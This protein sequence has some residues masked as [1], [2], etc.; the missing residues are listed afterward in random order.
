[1]RFIVDSSYSLMAP[2]LPQILKD[3]GVDESIN[4]YIFSTFSAALII[5]APLVG[6]YLSRYERMIFLR[7]GLFALGC[8]IL[9]FGLS[10]MIDNH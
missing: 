8:S 9:G 7:C 4:G 1:M 5:S 2:F 10:S 3:K 6:Y